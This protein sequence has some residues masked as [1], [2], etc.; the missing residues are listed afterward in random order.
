MHVNAQ[1]VEK[2]YTCFQTRDAAGMTACYHPAIVFC[3]PVF[4]RLAG[5]QATAMWTMLCGRAKDLTITFG[6]VQ[7]DEATGRAHWEARYSFGKTG[8]AVHN[9]IEAAFVFRDGLI[10]QHTDTFDLWRWTRMALG[11][12]GVVAGWTPMLQNTV[13]TDARRGLDKFMQGSAT[14]R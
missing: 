4:G 11:P 12:I 13:R 10:V 6:N 3:D 14:V 7:A 5:A 9:V 8:R 1:L 2:F